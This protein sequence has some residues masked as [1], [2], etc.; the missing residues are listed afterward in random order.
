MYQDISNS[1]I[2]P[3]TA[4][5]T[6]MSFRFNVTPFSPFAFMHTDAEWRKILKDILDPFILSVLSSSFEEK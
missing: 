3:S 5:P 1:H 4:L 2:L 6:P